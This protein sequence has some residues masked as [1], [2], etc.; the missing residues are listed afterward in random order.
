MSQPKSFYKD[1][2]IT[3]QALF[4][5]FALIMGGISIYLTDH[6]YSN[7]FPMTLEGGALCDINSFWNC[8]HTAN[9]PISNVF[10]VPISL[11]GLLFSCFLFLGFF[12]PK[13]EIEATN[14]ILLR[15]N[16]VG[17]IILFFYSIIALGGICPGCMVYYIFSALSAWVFFKNSNIKRVDGKV[18][19][20]YIIAALCVSGLAMA[21][22]EHKK[23]NNEKLTKALI[24][25]FDKLP[26]I[27]D[28]NP[29]NSY[30]YIKATE[31]FSDAP[32]RITKFSDYE[33][34]G[35][36]LMAKALEKVAKRF[37]GSIN[38]QY[39]F[40]P[41]DMNCNSTMKGPLHQNACKASYLASCVGDKFPVV[42][43]T[44]FD[45]QELINNIWLDNMA[46]RY[47]AVDCMNDETTKKKIIEHI[48]IGK[49]FEISGTP[50]LI[51]N[52][53]K[54]TRMLPADQLYVLLEHLKNKK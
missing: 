45:H 15:Y 26:D 23:S 13:P 52:G 40:F 5:L 14:H 29:S 50:T 48:E 34:P 42:T 22:L 43:D 27:G 16:L 17:C 53:K 11:F 41:L 28:P 9:S 49:K 2:N 31:N 38:I 6:Y 39:V 7:L 51:I 46:A 18:L 3:P 4:G 44:F 12:I 33:C 47:D 10:G 24:P 1:A 21:H 54:I 8:D 25:Q 35:C 37:E 36:R 32:I 30:F 19:G 20:G